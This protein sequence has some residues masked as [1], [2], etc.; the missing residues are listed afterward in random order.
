MWVVDIVGIL[1]TSTKN[2]KY[3]IIAIDYMTKWVESQPLSAITEEAAQNFFLD[4]IILRFGIPKVCVSDN[5]TQFIENKFQRNKKRLGGAKG[6]CAEK[7]PWV[8][9]AY[10]TTPQSSTGETPFKLT[11]KKDALVPVEVGIDSYKIDIY[12]VEINSFG[13]RANVDVRRRK[14]GRPPKKH[15]ILVAGSP[16]L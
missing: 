12:N 7:L 13:L 14:R 4:H 15:E 2:A 10:R 3:Y 6:R 16:I 8:L 9:W 1:P 5:G 11:Y